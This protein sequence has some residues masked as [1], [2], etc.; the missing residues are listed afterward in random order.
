MEE[1]R[2]LGVDVTPRSVY[3][4]EIDSLR[5][6]LD[7]TRKLYADA[8]KARMDAVRS[9]EH[10]TKALDNVANFLSSRISDVEK[11]LKNTHYV[12]ST[13]NKRHRGEE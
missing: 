10:L 8:D 7:Y 3:R 1:T 13:N 12:K 9:V 11:T 4:A 6:E 5:A 2:F